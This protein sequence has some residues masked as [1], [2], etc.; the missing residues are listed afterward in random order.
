MKLHVAKYNLEVTV[1]EGN[2]SID[3]DIMTE[4]LRVA[5]RECKNNT[6]LHH[7]NAGLKN[8]QKKLDRQSAIEVAAQL[9]KFA[10]E[11]PEK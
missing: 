1:P 8:F 11:H 4:V 2:P 5:T 6:E 9:L 10:Q 3:L 7:I